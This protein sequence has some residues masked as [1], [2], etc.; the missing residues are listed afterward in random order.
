MEWR[1]VS[2]QIPIGLK[3][4]NIQ[5]QTIGSNNQFLK[6]VKSM[7]SHACFDCVFWTKNFSFRFLSPGLLAFLVMSR[8]NFRESLKSDGEFI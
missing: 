8:C 1:G 7:L 3:K 6:P 2:G 5:Y 4:L